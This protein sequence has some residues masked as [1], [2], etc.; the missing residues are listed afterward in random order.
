MPTSFARAERAALADLLR[1]LGPDAPTLCEGWTTRDLAAHLVVRE[2]R[3]DSAPGIMIAALA[4]W[5]EKVRLKQAAKPYEQTVRLVA[6]GPPRLSV[7]GIPGV[8]AAANTMEYFVHLEDVRR[9]QPA[10]A[11]PRDLDPALTEILWKRAR[12]ASRTALRGVPVG[13]ALR[14]TDGP[15]DEPPVTI[16]KGSQSTKGAQGTPVVT[17]AGHP[18]EL[19]LYLFGRKEQA[20]VAIEGDEDAIRRLREARTGL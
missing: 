16:H 3:P 4:G 6:D 17:L 9:A 5:T 14:R 1:E 12:G 13:V 18:A 7:F 19:L 15:Y 2:H 20:Q 8:D 10:G 11:E